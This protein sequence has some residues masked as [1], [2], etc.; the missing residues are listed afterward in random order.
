MMVVAILWP[1]N[2]HGRLFNSDLCERLKFITNKMNLYRKMAKTDAFSLVPTS[3]W[4]GWTHFV[5]Q[6]CMFMNNISTQSQTIQN[7][8]C[9]C[10]DW[11]TQKLK[12]TMFPTSHKNWRF[13][14]VIFLILTNSIT[15]EPYV[16]WS[17]NRSLSYP[18]N[19]DLYIAFNA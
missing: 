19:W 8:L 7:E 11:G 14:V 2:P 18:I 12:Y 6:R 16:G 17:A 13:F 3:S 1:R 9:K 5:L 4:S 10:I 15:L